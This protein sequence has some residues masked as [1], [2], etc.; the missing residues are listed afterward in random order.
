MIL[1]IQELLTLPE[2]PS[3]PRLFS[4]VR[5]T[6]YLIL[7]ICFVDFCLS[8]CTFSFGHCVVC[9]SS[10][11]GFWLPPFGIFILFI[12]F[13]LPPFGIFKPFILQIQL[14]LLHTLIYTLKLTARAGKEQNCMTKNVIV[15]CHL[16]VTTYSYSITCIWS[17]YLPVDLI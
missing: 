7:D 4:G 8:F 17:I 9:S 16:Y 5:V 11:Y 10:I 13:W 3:S 6:R 1:Q 14:D 15:E 12:R 2:H